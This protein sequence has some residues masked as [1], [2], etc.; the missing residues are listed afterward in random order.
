M[1]DTFENCVKSTHSVCLKLSEQGQ[2][3]VLGQKTGKWGRG[4]GRHEAWLTSVRAKVSAPSER[5]G[6]GQRTNVV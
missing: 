1:P 3:T 4:P 6:P 2:K 5:E